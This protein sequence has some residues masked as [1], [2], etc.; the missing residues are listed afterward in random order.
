MAIKILNLTTSSSG[1]ESNWSIFKMVDAKRRNKLDVVR[2]DNLVYIQFNGRMIDK[3]KKLSSSSDVLLSEDAS[4]AQDWI[5]EG[6]YIDEEIDPVTGLSYNI[7]DEAMGATEAMEPR[8]SARVRELHE[9]EEFVSD[10]DES[11]HEM[12]MDDDVDYESDDGGVMST[13]DNEDEED[14][15]HP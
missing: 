13:K 11:D 14:M 8:R 12:D 1:C 4:R 10:E 5:C 3:R 7:I 15:P 6:A 9:V 2:R